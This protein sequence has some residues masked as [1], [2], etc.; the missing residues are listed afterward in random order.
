MRRFF[1]EGDDDSSDSQRGEPPARTGTQASLL[2]QE[3]SMDISRGSSVAGDV[4]KSKSDAP[5]GFVRAQMP[6]PPPPPPP[7]TT[8]QG[9]SQRNAATGAAVE[10]SA[11]Q[12][13]ADTLA[14]EGEPEAPAAPEPPKEV[15]ERLVQVGEGT[16]GKV[17][18]ARNIHTGALVALKR[19]RMEAE[20]DGFPV[21]S[22]REMK[23]L[24]SLR[25]PNVVS[26]FETMVS[27]SASYLVTCA[28]LPWLTISQVTSTWSSST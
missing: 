19:I 13:P 10:L 2:S 6:P 11:S 18:K 15:Y 17:Y 8:E 20:R 22:V 12:T 9:E 5:D 26:L 24:Q 25:H 3:D 21:T 23:L 14:A 7:Q 27:R 16:Y 1:G 4:R 28:L